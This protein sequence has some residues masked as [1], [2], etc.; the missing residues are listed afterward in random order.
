MAEP[1]PAALNLSVVGAM[2]SAHVHTRAARFHSM[3]HRAS[4]VMLLPRADSPYCQLAIRREPTRRFW[5]LAALREQACA[6]RSVAA[7]VYQ[8]QYALGP[9]A[10]LTVILG[11]RPLAV[12]TMGG[13][14]LFEEQ[15]SLSRIEQW[16]VRTW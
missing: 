2:R 8:V 14:V 3:G 1:T 4:T 12:S 16:L 5:W 11:R 7:A 13:D 9:L 6:L 15:L 10:C